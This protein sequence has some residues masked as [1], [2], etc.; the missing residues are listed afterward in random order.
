MDNNTEHEERI[1]RIVQIYDRLP[2]IA[3]VQL[4][5]ILFQIRYGERFHHCLESFDLFR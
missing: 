4:L 3:R 2:F 1:T 5:V